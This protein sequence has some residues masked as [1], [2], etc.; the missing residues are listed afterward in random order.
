MCQISGGVGKWFSSY[1]FKNKTAPIQKQAIFKCLQISPKF[2]QFSM[3]QN[4]SHWG[5]G[6]HWGQE[7][8]HNARSVIFYFI[9]YIFILLLFH[10]LFYCIW[11]YGWNTLDLEHPHTSLDMR[12]FYTLKINTLEFSA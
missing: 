9:L 2:Q 6:I 3:C 10:H 5:T 11:I 12:H 8:A 1:D 7:I 4:F